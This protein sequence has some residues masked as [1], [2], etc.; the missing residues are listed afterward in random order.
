MP[1]TPIP[2]GVLRLAEAFVFASPQ[3]VT[4]AALQPLLPAPLEARAT[5]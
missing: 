1:D 3:P 2:D 4:P 5:V